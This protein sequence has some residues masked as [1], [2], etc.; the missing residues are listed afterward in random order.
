MRIKALCG[1]AVLVAMSGCLKT[2]TQLR[3]ETEDRVSAAKPVPAQVKDVQSEGDYAVDELKSEI[4]RLTGRIED[5]ERKGASSAG[6][7]GPASRDE[8]KKIENRIHELE[9][10]QAQLIEEVQKMRDTVATVADPTEHFEKAKAAY[11]AEDY[12]KAVEEYSV[13]L[14]S[15]RAKHVEEATFYRAESYFQLKQ[16]KKA[17]VDYSKFPEKFTKSE[18]MPIVL[19]KI[20]KSFDALGMK[21]DARGFYQELIEKHPKS[22]EAKKAKALLKPAHKKPRS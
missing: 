20:G 3:E 13:Y 10:A 11:K 4:T 5:L 6:A 17:I 16:Y 15:T 1:V 18:R 7:G 21:E 19:F 8:L 14:K 9:Q 2:R 22:P 12:E